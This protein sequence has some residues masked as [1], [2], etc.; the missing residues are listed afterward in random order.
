MMIACWVVPL[1]RGYI[2]HLVNSTIYDTMMS[3]EE[4]RSLAGD[5]EKPNVDEDAPLESI[6]GLC[7][8]LCSYARRDIYK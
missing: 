5:E 1:V 7:R 6:Q 8:E 4:G 3:P 2:S